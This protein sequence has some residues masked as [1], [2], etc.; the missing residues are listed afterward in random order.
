MLGK[1]VFYLMIDQVF[2]FHSC[3]LI[4][5]MLHREFLCQL[6]GCIAF[7]DDDPFNLIIAKVD[8]N[9]K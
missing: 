8:V 1:N 4:E 6:L 9:E 3:L 7:I 2:E 5:A